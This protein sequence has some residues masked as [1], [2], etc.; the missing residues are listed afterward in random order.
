M[1]N[2]CR[3]RV[4]VL[5]KLFFHSKNLSNNSTPLGTQLKGYLISERFC[6]TRLLYVVLFGVRWGGARGG[7]IWARACWQL[8]HPRIIL[9]SLSLALRQNA[10]IQPSVSRCFDSSW[11]AAF[12][13]CSR[14]RRH[15]PGR[16][17][18]LCVQSVA[19]DSAE[20]A[21]RRR[22]KSVVAYKIMRP[23]A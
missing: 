7:K 11:C 22:Y 23:I 12:I 4:C 18:V 16:R 9:L 21:R 10:L 14:A 6:C 15:G 1:T 3:I 20:W 8:E 5:S 2:Q 19:A 13:L 17:Q